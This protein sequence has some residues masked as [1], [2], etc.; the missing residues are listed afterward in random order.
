M[1][2]NGLFVIILAI[3][4]LHVRSLTR[5]L[6]SEIK[7]SDSW[8][9]LSMKLTTELREEKAKKQANITSNGTKK[10]A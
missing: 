6:K 8:R 5:E 9:F 3:Y 7:K 10:V 1:I 4:I 2:I